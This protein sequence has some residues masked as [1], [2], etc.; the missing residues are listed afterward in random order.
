MLASKGSSTCWS[1]ASTHAGM[2]GVATPL[3]PQIGSPP[4][5]QWPVPWVLPPPRPSGVWELTKPEFKFSCY[6]FN[7]CDLA[8]LPPLSEPWSLLEMGPRHGEE[9]WVA[10]GPDH[11]THCDLH[12]FG[13][14]M[15]PCMFHIPLFMTRGHQEK[16]SARVGRTRWGGRFYSLSVI[17]YQC[18]WFYTLA[19]VYGVC[20]EVDITSSVLQ[21]KELRL[22]RCI[23]FSSK[24]T[25]I[26]LKIIQ[27]T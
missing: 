16:L 8:S 20:M 17:P 15:S 22:K 18:S 1:G 23:Y 6:F 3:T 9:E 4:S 11:H 12:D 26:N 19:T 2:P 14:D 21:M 24:V 10:S 13:Y 27:G 7:L 5:D 25:F